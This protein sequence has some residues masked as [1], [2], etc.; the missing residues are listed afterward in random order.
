MKAIG[1]S[2]ALT[3]KRTSNPKQ[4]GCSDFQSV[5]AQVAAFGKDR[6]AGAVV[7][8]IFLS[9]VSFLK[10]IGWRLS[11]WYDGLIILEGT[12]DT[13]EMIDDKA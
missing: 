8:V 12:P 2:G 10:T 13:W 11:F 6:M 7:L 5:S 4:S 1:N 9:V 3:M